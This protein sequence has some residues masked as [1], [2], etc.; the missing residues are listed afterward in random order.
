MQLKELLR[1][2]IYEAGETKR[3]NKAKKT[4]AGFTSVP[5]PDVD[6]DQRV[7]PKLKA[8]HARQQAAEKQKIYG[9]SPHAYDGSPYGEPQG[10][11]HE[12]S[13]GNMGL[14]VVGTGM[15]FEDPAS[16]STL[17]HQGTTPHGR[18]KDSPVPPA[19]QQ[20]ASRDAG[21]KVLFGRYYDGQGNY[22]GR[23]QGGKWVDAVSDPNAK[24]MMEMYNKIKEIESMKHTAKD[25][26]M[27]KEMIREVIKHYK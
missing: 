16:R 26:E 9:D 14:D 24:S 2:A 1:N 11:E 5:V 23:S 17:Q 12:L 21:G 25:K 20:A 10:R 27:V 7:T 22:L 3:R 18:V 15:G 8:A 4:K 6:L 13:R 19:V